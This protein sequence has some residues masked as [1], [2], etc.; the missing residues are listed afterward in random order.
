M[1]WRPSLLPSHLSHSY[2]LQLAQTAATSSSQASSHS[3]ASLEQDN[4]VLRTHAAACQ[5]R[6]C[7]LDSECVSRECAGRIRRTT[8]L[9]P[10]RPS[11]AS[12]H[13]R[14][15]LEHDN[16]VFRTHPST[17]QSRAWR[18]ESQCVSRQCADR[19]RRAT[20]LRPLRHKSGQQ[21]LAGTTRA[22]FR[23]HAA[24][25]SVPGMA[26]RFTVCLT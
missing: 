12:S 15:P 10:L 13:S 17:D 23:T 1:P 5:S 24:A 7:W 22:V 9:R 6:V 20:I 8:I 21:P 4:P 11:K 19:I 3:W 2:Q 14:A 26:A 25:G 16:P 18:P